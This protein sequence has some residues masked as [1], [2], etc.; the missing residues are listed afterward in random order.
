MLRYWR[1]KEG[2]TY[3]NAKQ[4]VKEWQ[5]EIE[6]QEGALLNRF[7]ERRPRQGLSMS[8]SDGGA[9]REWEQPIALPN[10]DLAPERR[11]DA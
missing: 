3:P 1:V 9:M 5:Q 10:E 11:H 7:R 4:M 6:R 2:L 8:A